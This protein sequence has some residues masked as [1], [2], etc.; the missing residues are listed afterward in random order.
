M[1]KITLKVPFF[2]PSRAFLFDLGS[3]PHEACPTL[4]SGMGTPSSARSMGGSKRKFNTI[5]FATPC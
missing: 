4:P 2:K 1:K 3:S 5:G